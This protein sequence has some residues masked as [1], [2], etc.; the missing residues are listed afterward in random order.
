MPQL[1]TD[2]PMGQLQAARHTYPKA[3]SHDT[4]FPFLECIVLSSH[5]VDCLGLSASIMP[6]RIPS[7]IAQSF[8]R[9]STTIASFLVPFV[10]LSIRPAS[11]LSSLSDN[12]GAYS[13]KIRRGRGPSSGKGK[14]SGR[15]Q[16]GQKARGK[17][18]KQFNGGQ[19]PEALTHGKMGFKNVY[20]AMCGITET[21][22]T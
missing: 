22:L 9:P 7:L 6:P 16:K 15:G 18:P 11:I 5:Q 21:P 12:S 1:V 13:K 10:H 19:T 14:T 4:R 3:S 20:V 8:T 2:S 17:V